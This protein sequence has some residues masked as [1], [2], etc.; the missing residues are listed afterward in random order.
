MRDL[1]IETQR[2]STY[3]SICPA[4]LPDQITT[5]GKLD[6]EAPVKN[7]TALRGA[8][9]ATLW[10]SRQCR[11]VAACLCPDCDECDSCHTRVSCLGFRRLRG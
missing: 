1:L 2:S 9:M 6:E 4:V 7:A 5:Q 8:L 11:G 3:P 10:I